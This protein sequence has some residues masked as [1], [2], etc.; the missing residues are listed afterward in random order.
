MMKSMGGLGKSVDCIL[1]KARQRGCTTFN[2][3]RHCSHVDFRKGDYK[4]LCAFADLI[5]GWSIFQMGL[6]N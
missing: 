1:R 5:G 6:Q 3:I 4:V 2:V